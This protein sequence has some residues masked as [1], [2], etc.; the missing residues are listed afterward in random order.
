[1]V[2]RTSTI[3]TLYAALFEPQP[4]MRTL[5]RCVFVLVITAVTALALHPRAPEIVTFENADKV[6]HLL[7]FG[8]LAFL[9]QLM[10][11]T[12]MWH[13]LQNAGALMVYGAGIEVAQSFVPGRFAS[14]ADWAADGVGV[15]LGLAAVAA[16]RVGLKSWLPRQ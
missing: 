7:A 5:W 3:T 14:A 2:L 1:M 10:R 13:T 8:T 9:A 4:R 11:S 6:R 16:I 15:A 12:R